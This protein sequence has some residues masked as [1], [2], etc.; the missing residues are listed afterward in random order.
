MSSGSGGAAAAEPVGTELLLRGG[1]RK[2][3]LPGGSEPG[4]PIL[5]FSRVVASY[6]LYAVPPEELAG[7]PSAAGD[8]SF[9]KSAGDRDDADSDDTET[10]AS[11]PAKIHT[12]SSSMTKGAQ[13]I[14][15]LESKRAGADTGITFIVGAG[16][17]MSTIVPGL[18]IAL[19]TMRTGD[20]ARVVVPSVKGF[21]GHHVG[22]LI[23]GDVL[24]VYDI[25]I[26]DVK[27]EVDLTA[28]KDRSVT[29][30]VVVASKKPVHLVYESTVKA[31]IFDVHPITEKP[32]PAVETHVE[33]GVTHDEHIDLALLSMGEGELAEI[34]YRTPQGPR[35]LMIQLLSATNPPA[36][37][38]FSNE[39]AL[40]QASQRKERGNVLLKEKQYVKALQAYQHGLRFLK[41]DRFPGPH[42]SDLAAQRDNLHAVLCGNAS[43]VCI[44]AGWHDDAVA[45]ATKAID[46]DPSKTKFYFRRAKALKLLGRFE[47]ARADLATAQKCAS[48]ASS[49]MD[50]Q[51]VSAEFTD[52]D[53]C[54]KRAAEAAALAASGE[55]AGGAAG[56]RSAG[57]GGHGG[58][59]RLQDLKAILQNL[60]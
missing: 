7:K 28:T 24:L 49:P 46:L 31:K 59:T 42:G 48:E 36:V 15:D 22:P 1:V 13:H 16:D 27:H 54:E 37:E 25:T 43:Q 23:H 8:S 18:E 6:V 60:L 20:R 11:S 17:N 5:P 32:L 41:N 51:I 52:L 19:L 55:H 29:K 30:Y 3:T 10:D 56:G 45:F 38:S 35:K 57:S 9:N 40:E 58:G 4:E 44:D 14:Q 47:A 26:K 34:A 33:I 12:P 39:A 50:E 2:I 21:E 53:E